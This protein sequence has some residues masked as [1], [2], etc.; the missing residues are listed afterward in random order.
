MSSKEAKE[1]KE[2]GGSPDEE[3]SDESKDEDKKESSDE[4][5]S[6]EHKDVCMRCR[7]TELQEGWIDRNY[8]KVCRDF[9][10]GGYEDLLE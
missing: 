10:Q 1:A 7:T 3:S 8:C 6:D 9:I 5:S 4:E 2:I